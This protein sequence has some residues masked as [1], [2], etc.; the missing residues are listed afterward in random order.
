MTDVFFLHKIFIFALVIL[1]TLLETVIHDTTRSHFHIA[2]CLLFT[3][4]SLTIPQNYTS[5]FNLR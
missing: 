2:S 4:S 1:E 3:L 5:P